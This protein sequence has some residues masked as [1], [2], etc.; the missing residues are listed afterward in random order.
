LYRY[1]RNPMYVGVLSV[2]FGWAVLYSSPAVTVY[3]FV[4][5]LCFYSFIVFFEEPILSK[6]FGTDYEQYCAEVPRWLF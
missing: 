5:A 3:G 2:I 6:R 1:S 4:I